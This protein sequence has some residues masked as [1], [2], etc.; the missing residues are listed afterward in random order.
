VLFL[1]QALGSVFGNSLRPDTWGC[2]SPSQSQ[3]FTDE[4]GIDNLRSSAQSFVHE[5]LEGV[6]SCSY[7]IEE[8][9]QSYGVT[10][11]PTVLFD[12]DKFFEI[13]NHRATKACKNLFPK[14]KHGELALSLNTF[15]LFLESFLRCQSMSSYI[16]SRPKTEM[17]YY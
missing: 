4:S 6:A 15:D 5:L 12:E 1:A 13:K 10:V 9:T 11:E 2:D 3:S 17:V 8:A 7:W 16:S 14:C